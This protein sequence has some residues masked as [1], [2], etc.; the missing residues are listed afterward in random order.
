M[1]LVTPEVRALIGI[2]SEPQFACDPVEPGAVRRFAQAIMDDDPAYAPGAGADGRFGGPIAPLLFPNHMLRRAFGTPD[3]LQQRAQDPDFDGVVPAAGLPP[4]PGLS[5]LPT[6]NGGSAFEFY[7]FAR[8][9]EAVTLRQRYADVHEKA[10]GKA[11]WVVVDIEGELRTVAGEL[12]L[13]SHRTLLR[14]V[15]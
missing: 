15:P 9:G 2:W 6:L 12:L 3:V 10:T 5:N 4:L 1:S 8:H 14:R 7:R 11:V 13:R